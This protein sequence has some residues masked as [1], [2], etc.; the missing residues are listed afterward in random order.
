MIYKGMVSQLT[1]KNAL[2]RATEMADVTDLREGEPPQF[3]V[4]PLSKMY[5]PMKIQL[6]LLSE[7]KVELFC[8]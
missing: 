1:A 8:S 6:T 2:V 5:R 4:M 7:K 3:K